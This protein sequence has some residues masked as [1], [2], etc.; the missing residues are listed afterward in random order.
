M[1]TAAQPIHPVVARR[2]KRRQRERY[3]ALGAVVLIIIV[4]MLGGLRVE[5]DRMPA[6]RQA[7]PAADHLSKQ[8]PGVYEAWA[9][10]AEE[11][12]LGYVVIGTAD[13]YGGPLELAVAV[14]TEGV[15]TDYNIVAYKETP[16]WMTRI[17]NSRLPDSLVGKSYDDPFE[18]GNDIDVVTGATYTSRAMAEAA[19][20]GSQDAARLLGFTVPEAPPPQIE[21]GIPEIVLLGLFAVGFVGHRREFRFKKQARWGSM[22]VGMMVLGFIY[23]LPLTLAYFVKAILGYWP[24]WQT[25][26]YWYFLFFGILI[27]A[28]I[29][30]KNPYCSWFCPFGASQECL[31]AVGGAKVRTPRKHRNWLIWAQ[32][33]LALAAILLGV[34]FRSPGLSSYEL[35]GTLFSFV[36]TSIQFVAL[37]LVLLASLYLKRPWCGFL[38][39]LHPVVEFFHLMREWVK[40][41]WRK[42]NPAKKTA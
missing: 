23:N 32:R 22:I 7:W 13:G 6:V 2:L 17:L 5:A 3:L 1:T 36:G 18:L 14:D 37:A 42:V 10:S 16:T 24:Q 25:N 19:L 40:E 20:Y 8:A 12:L 35:F 30:K 9:D 34:Y 15:I 41:L 29:D 39:P 28:I 4:Y 26:L 21:F 11:T 31:G 33:I 27:V 38:C